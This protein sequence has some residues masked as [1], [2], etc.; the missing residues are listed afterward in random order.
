MKS[1]VLFLEPNNK[2]LYEIHKVLNGI[3]PSTYKKPGEWKPHC[4]VMIDENMDK[5]IMVDK[6]INENFK[7]FSI[8]AKKLLLCEVYPMKIIETFELK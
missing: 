4:S 1:N 3:S 7:P 8:T 5:L 2:K 6:I